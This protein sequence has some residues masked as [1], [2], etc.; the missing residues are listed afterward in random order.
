MPDSIEIFEKY[1]EKYENWYKKGDGRL[2]GPLEHKAINRAY[3]HFNDK[4][5]IGLEV[6]AD[7]RNTDF[8]GLSCFLCC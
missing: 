7:W 8:I 3:N 2:L 6:G 1:A 4:N 5:F